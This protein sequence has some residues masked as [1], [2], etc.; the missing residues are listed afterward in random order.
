MSLHLI[1]RRS[2]TDSDYIIGQAGNPKGG[3]SA[4][5]RLGSSGKRMLENAKS[6]LLHD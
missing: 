2:I 5:S 6:Y 3:A 1:G 4:S